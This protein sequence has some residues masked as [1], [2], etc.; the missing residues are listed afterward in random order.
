MAYP[1]L[2]VWQRDPALLLLRFH[3]PLSD[4]GR[5]ACQSIRVFI[6][7]LSGN[8]AQAG[9]SGSFG[10]TDL[11]AIGVQEAP[12]KPMGPSDEPR[13]LTTARQAY[14]TLEV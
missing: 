6:L 8:L 12:Q 4:E 1:G 13:S 7:K 5:G 11:L 2:A 10:D 14:E 3:E 9:C